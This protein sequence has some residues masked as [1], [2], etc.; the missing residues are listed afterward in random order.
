MGRWNKT[1]KIFFFF[2]LSRLAQCTPDYCLPDEKQSYYCNAAS[3]VYAFLHIVFRVRAAV[4][5]NRIFGSNTISKPGFFI[6]V[7]FSKRFGDGGRNKHNNHKLSVSVRL[8]ART[9]M[10]RTCE[11]RDPSYM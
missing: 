5:V 7:F 3:T 1:T 9:R 8:H 4:R 6:D 11:E 2:S 10:E